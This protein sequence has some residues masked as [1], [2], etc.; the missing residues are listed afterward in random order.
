MAE[1]IEQAQKAL[2]AALQHE[3]ARPV[4]I[5][6]AAVSLAVLLLAAFSKKRGKAQDAKGTVI[7]G[8]VR[9]STR[10][11]K[12]PKP[13]YPEEVAEPVAKTPRAARTPKS[14]AK[15]AAPPVEEKE[16]NTVTPKVRRST[17]TAAKTPKTA[18]PPTTATRRRTRA[19]AA[20]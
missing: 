15:P 12:Q 10:Q 18:E 14:A 16:A 8:G 9:R 4:L 5:S 1:H 19:T 7:V 17:R 6:L 3:M 11:H 13:V 2:L 20:A